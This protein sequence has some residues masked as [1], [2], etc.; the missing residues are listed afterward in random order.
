MKCQTDNLNVE[1]DAEQGKWKLDQILRIKKWNLSCESRVEY[2][3]IKFKVELNAL[4]LT[5]EPDVLNCWMKSCV[6]NTQANNSYK[7]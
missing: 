2:R 7:Q 6:G 1:F 3:I 4:N 5:I